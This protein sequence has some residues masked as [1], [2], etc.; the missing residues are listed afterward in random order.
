[1]GGFGFPQMEVSH[2]PQTK[3]SMI[4]ASGYCIRRVAPNVKVARK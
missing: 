2:Q 4:T 3:L 1:M